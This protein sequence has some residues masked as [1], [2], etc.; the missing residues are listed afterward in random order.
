MRDL[1]IDGYKEK[2]LEGSLLLCTL[3]RMIM[4]SLPIGLSTSPAMGLYTVNSTKNRFHIEEQIL[5]SFIDQL[6]ASIRFLTLLNL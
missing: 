4:L 6:V 2:K 3:S 5:N 1:I